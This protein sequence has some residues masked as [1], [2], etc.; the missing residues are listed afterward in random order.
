VN[1]IPKGRSAFGAFLFFGAAMALLAG[2]TLLWPGTRL[3]L[4][5]RLN[6][7]AYRELAPLGRAIGLPF[8][9]LGVTLGSAG[10]GWFRRRKWAWWLAV[11]VIATQVAGNLANIVLGRVVEV[12]VG[13][14]IAAALL[15]YLL[16][17]AVRESFE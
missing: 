15:F 12:A 8:L 4:I 5:W 11:A 9:L 16:R 10:V 13:G 7:R 14:T 2:A 17:A 6:M 1:R 3:D